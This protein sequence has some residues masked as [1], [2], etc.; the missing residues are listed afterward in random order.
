M[1]T[2]S[3]DYDHPTHCTDVLI[4]WFSNLSCAH[5]APEHVM[6]RGE[7]APGAHVS[8]GLGLSGGW[9]EHL[10]LALRGLGLGRLQQRGRGAEASHC[11][12]QLTVQDPSR[13]LQHF[14]N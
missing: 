4:E 13:Q 10:L 11:G 2:G 6:L 1:F 3:T 7:E 8:H 14:Q 5:D 12:A 9:S